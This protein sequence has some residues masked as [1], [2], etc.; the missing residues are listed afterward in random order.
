M[1]R[2]LRGNGDHYSLGLFL[3]TPRPPRQSQKTLPVVMTD[4]RQ[5]NGRKFA[6]GNLYRGVKGLL[7]RVFACLRKAPATRTVPPRLVVRGGFIPSSSRS[8]VTACQTI[9]LRSDL[10]IGLVTVELAESLSVMEIQIAD[11]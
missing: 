2:A 9:S 1:K 3:F 11:F 6:Y 5:A 8:F 7:R 10:W 4:L